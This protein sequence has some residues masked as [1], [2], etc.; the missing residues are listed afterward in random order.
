MDSKTLSFFFSLIHSFMPVVEIRYLKTAHGIISGLFTT[1]EEGAAALASEISRLRLKKNTAYR[2]INYI[3]DEY[4]GDKDLN[5]LFTGVKSTVKDGDISKICFFPIDLDPI[6]PTGVSATDAEK[7]YA[8]T[9]AKAIIADMNE[10]G[11]TQPIQIDSGNGYNIMYAVSVDNNKENAQLLKKLNTVIAEKY[12][13]SN[14]DVDKSVTNSG[15]I[16]K[17]PGTISAKGE[18]SADRPHRFSRLISYP[19]EL[20]PTSIETI[21][22][23]IDANS[24]SPTAKESRK[25]SDAKKKLEK[26][27]SLKQTAK[28]A[29]VGGWLDSYNIA[30]RIEEKEYEGY[31][32]TMYILEDCPFADHENKYCSFVTDFGDN[33]CFFKCHHDHCGQTIYDMLDKYPIQNQLPLINSDDK[34]AKVYNSV[35]SSIELIADGSR[36]YV[37]RKDTGL[38]ISCDAVEYDLYITETAQQLGDLIS[39]AR[40]TTIK[41]NIGALFARYAVNKRVNRRIAYHDGKIYYAADVGRVYEIAIDGVTE[42]SGN[43]VLFY[44]GI[45]Y[46]PQCEP[47]LTS[48]AADLPM[49]IRNTFNI[50]DEYLLCFIAQLCTL[51]IS[52]INSPILVLSGGQGTS[53]STTSKKIKSIVDPADTDVMSIP[54]KEDS[55]YAS[56]S[57]S[58]LV[59]Y[60]N[61]TN[62]SQA[63]SDIFCISVTKGTV[64]KR[65]LYSDNS[66]VDIRLDANIILNGID[67]I[68]KKSDLAERCNIIYLDR[69]TKRLTEKKVWAEFDS[70]KPR[71]LGSIFNAVAE[72]LNYVDEMNKAITELPRMADFTVY[73]AAMIKAVHLDHEAFLK[74]YTGNTT[75]LI[76][77]TA[78][79]DSFVLLIQKFL[80]S[81]NGNWKAEP[82]M[83]L[84][85]L[86]DYSKRNLLGM[87]R[88]NP[89]TLSRKLTAIET[90]LSALG[91]TCKRERVKSKRFISMHLS[92][93]PSEMNEEYQIT[94]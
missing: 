27:S 16:F 89:N 26:A 1:D 68:I 2:T 82:S 84:E 57:S 36:Q 74:Q 70:I 94:S 51:F 40:V 52:D 73:G 93:D 85:Q 24:V 25:N 34:N 46:K 59:A 87:E 8:K 33:T 80:E 23:Y 39:A 7:D 20:Q 91:I 17:L 30:Y 64:S 43:D 10:F 69:I 79:N 14:V 13:D 4:L 78:T 48:P 18:N 5:K 76:S 41:N 31:P 47:D 71:L 6:R 11:F 65:K 32:C 12:S 86:R 67:E 53:K 63:F 58:Y 66:L 50:S 61:I 90:N 56:L 62:I 42:Y 35:V 75:Q 83:L 15:R 37:K 88:Y 29:D 49:L 54:D 44:Y 55:L 28:I 22:A 60:D 45:G 9:K 38:L 77:D 3:S 21:Q 72:G 92:H 19:D 81:K